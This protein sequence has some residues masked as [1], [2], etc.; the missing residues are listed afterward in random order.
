M[1]QVVV[2]CSQKIFDG[3]VWD[4]VWPHLEPRDCMRMRAS[5][6]LWNSFKKVWA[7]WCFPLLLDAGGIGV[8]TSKETVET[9][10][11][12]DCLPFSKEK[13]RC[14]CCNRKCTCFEALLEKP[15]EGIPLAGSGY[16]TGRFST[17]K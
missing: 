17:N 11:K 14:A 15:T 12:F 5:A 4:G 13:V 1:A 10:S 2:M 8:H 3:V 9:F 6:S 16:N 7:R